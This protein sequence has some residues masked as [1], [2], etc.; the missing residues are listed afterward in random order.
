MSAVVLLHAAA[1]TF[2]AGVVWMVQVVHYPLFA[3]VGDDGFGAYEA[4][5]SS[6]IGA[7]IMLPWALQGVT[8]AWLL[9][10][11]PDGVPRW[12]VLVAAACA[13]TTVL[14]TVVLSVPAHGV[15]AGGFDAAAHGR[16]VAT[17]WLRTAA[18]TLGSAVS[19]AILW[20]FRGMPPA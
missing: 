13:A 14:V 3:A 4:S 1:T 5:H 8:T 12:L 2:L 19:L 11:H 16:L 6:R 18:W 7:L 15:L 17:N 10:A 20:Q 9:L